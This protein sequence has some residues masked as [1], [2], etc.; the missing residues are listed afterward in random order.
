MGQTTAV[1]KGTICSLVRQELGSPGDLPRAARDL[2]GA[3]GGDGEL[4][5]V[6]ARQA[7]VKLW[8]SQVLSPKSRELT[9]G[10]STFLEATE[11]EP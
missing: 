1:S 10:K 7:R 6:S 8:D 9:R 2:S 5:A 11:R 4:R 3:S